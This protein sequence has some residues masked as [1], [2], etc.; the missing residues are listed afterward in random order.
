MPSCAC[1]FSRSIC[2]FLH[3]LVLMACLATSWTY[4]ELHRMHI[5]HAVECCHHSL[6]NC[7]DCANTQSG[8]FIYSFDSDT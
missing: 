5:K 7:D 4:V 1:K 8:G 2:L 3:V 6:P